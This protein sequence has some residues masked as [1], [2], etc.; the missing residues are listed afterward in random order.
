L[1]CEESVEVGLGD[2]V[3]P[4]LADGPEAVVG[5]HAAGQPAVDY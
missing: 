1:V 3:F 4:S 5:E 2:Q